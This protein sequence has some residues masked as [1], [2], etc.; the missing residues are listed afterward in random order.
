MSKNLTPLTVAERVFGSIGAVAVAAG[1]SSKAAYHW[2]WQNT[3][4]DAG[5]FRSIRHVRL[6][7]TAA[8]A[9]GIDLPLDWLVYGAREDQVAALMRAVPPAVAKVAA[10]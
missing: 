4:H 2:R 5:D 10:E 7:H 1:Q 8:H 9:K 3:N 6:L